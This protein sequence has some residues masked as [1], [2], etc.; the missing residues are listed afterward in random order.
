MGPGF[1]S[2]RVHQKI[3]DTEN[4]VVYFLVPRD[5]EPQCFLPYAKSIGCGN[6]GKEP[7]SVPNAAKPP[8]LLSTLRNLFA[9]CRS[10]LSSYSPFS[11]SSIFWSLRDIVPTYFLPCAKNIGCGNFGKEP[12][13]SP[14]ATKPP[15]LLSTLRN[16][17]AEC[18]S[19]L[20][21]IRIKTTRFLPCRF[22]I[23]AP[24]GDN[25]PLCFLPY[26]KSIGCGNF[27]KEPKSAPTAA[28]PP[29]LLSTL[30]N[31]LAECRSSL[32]SYS[33]FSVSSIFFLPCAKSIGCG[34]F[35]KEPKSALNAAKPP[36]LLSTLRNLLAECRSSLSSYSPFSVS[37]IFFLPYAK[38][39]G[40]GNFGKEPKSLPTA[41]KPPKLLSTLR[42]LLAECRS[43]QIIIR[44]KITRL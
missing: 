43:S 12:K 3:D 42:N 24:S 19:S 8:K 38:N 39:I 33:P 9:E 29:K 30:R 17:F 37:S 6:F 10:S 23:G 5:I 35:G 32:S 15:K 31:L 11:V 22:C 4:R 44:I 28:K 21:I 18:R 27:G 14:N 41:A 40:C 2:L 26:A 20:N 1:E 16:L 36:K 25:A 34:N 13:S 7:K